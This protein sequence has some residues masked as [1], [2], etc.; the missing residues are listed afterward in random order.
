[1]GPKSKKNK[2]NSGNTTW[3]QVQIAGCIEGDNLDGFAGL[4]VLENYDSSFLSGDLKR[5]NKLYLNNELDGEIFESKRRRHDSDDEPDKEKVEESEGIDIQEVKKPAKKKKTK[6]KVQKEFN[7]LPGQFVLLNPPVI[8]DIFEDPENA[9]IKA[10]WNGIGIT[11]DEIIRALVELK[12]KTS[13]E[14]QKLTI[15]VSCY[16]KVDILGAAET[17]SGKTL[18]FGLPIIQCIQKRLKD[19][20][21]EVSNFFALILTP[22]RELAQQ[23]YNHLNAVAKYTNV[24]IASIIGGLAT[25]KQERVLKSNPHIVIATPGRIW[26]LFNDGNQHLQ[27][28]VN[29]KHLV[30]D[31]TDR[32]I[33]KGHFGEMEKILELLN[34]AE[35]NPNRQTF[36]F[37]AT[38]TMLHDLPDYITKKKKKFVKPAEM[39]REQRTDMFAMMFGMKN[40]KV[41]DITDN[42][43]V[44]GK[45]IESRIL[46]S[47]D[48][49]DFHL[50]YILLNFPG[51]T[52]VF[53]NSID[54]VKRTV[55]VLSHLN[56]SP[57]CIHGQM[58]QKQRLKSLEKFQKQAESVLV[59]TNCAAR[60]LDI[61]NIQH[62]IHYQVPITGEDY[63]HRSGRT[64]RANKEGLS[65]LIM[66][67]N[68]IK[69]FL[70]LQ[71]TLGR[72]EDL[73]MFPIDP[74]IMKNVK[75]RVRLARE[76]ES[77]DLQVR[78]L[79]DN[80]NWK[81]K[82]AD[83]IG[84]L[85]SDDSENESNTNR[86]LKQINLDLK[87]KKLQLGKLLSMSIVPANI[88][89][90]KFPIAQ[91][92]EKIEMNPLEIIKANTVQQKNSKQFKTLKLFKKRK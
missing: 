91:L 19:H 67:Q 51:R 52:I 77:T 82:A 88:H 30:I 37:S 83:D 40:P 21:D 36:V 62:V 15:P 92:N 1:M 81:K 72:N 70:K 43:G 32:M 6:E 22:T 24:T 60:G 74:K 38:L 65:I 84:I 90:L 26:E 68:E 75:D 23:I 3:K 59:A 29:V 17:G 20:E 27:K 18:A 57:I 8:D 50:Y 87:H 54:C 78:R 85:D 9:E 16:G 39:T 7:T 53:C 71:K 48:E 55:S 28:L 34:S 45:V 44:A 42:S 12:F 31:E 73:P 35:S 61:P 10:T 64:A 49:K 2:K 80:R 46:C 13:T 47:L 11:S 25:V 69:N 66:E 14:I 79:N 5:R 58:E 89:S 4:E 56:V 76:I 41:F 63:V 86:K 33:E